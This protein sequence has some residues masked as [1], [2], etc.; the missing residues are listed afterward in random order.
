MAKPRVGL[1]LI[2]F[3]VIGTSIQVH[4]GQEW[5]SAP[6]KSKIC[7]SPDQTCQQA[8][9]LGE[10]LGKSSAELYLLQGKDYKQA[11]TQGDWQLQDLLYATNSRRD[12]QC[13]A[14]GY[15]KSFSRQYHASLGKPGPC[16]K[17]NT[18]KCDC[19]DVM[20]K[21][22]EDLIARLE[23]QLKSI[24]SKKFGK[25]SATQAKL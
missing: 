6:D 24:R 21:K 10:T 12:Q 8:H 18:A 16:V 17:T 15:H 11:T 14:D 1:L 20:D 4:F 7:L 13:L 3:A 19:C 23:G 25:K 22:Y 5:T 9:Q 2:C